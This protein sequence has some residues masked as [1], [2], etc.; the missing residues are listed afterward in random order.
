MTLC[1]HTTFYVEFAIGVAID[2]NVGEGLAA[3]ICLCHERG[4][5]FNIALLT[6]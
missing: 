1:R 2:Y 4:V 5:D 3:P 6:Y